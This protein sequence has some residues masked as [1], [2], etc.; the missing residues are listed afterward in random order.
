MIDSYLNGPRTLSNNRLS[1]LILSEGE[2]S[3]GSLANYE[4]MVCAAHFLGDGMALH[5]FANDFLNL[6]GS[7]KT[8]N[9][10]KMDLRSEYR[11]RVG[12]ISEVCLPAEH[13]T[14]I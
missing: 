2:K 10:L 1:Y 5:Q 9:E 6:L 7:E 12:D 13:Q 8:D 3:D 11:L 14:S 4:L